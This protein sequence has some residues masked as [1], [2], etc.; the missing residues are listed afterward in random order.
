MD[1]VDSLIDIITTSPFSYLLSGVVALFVVIISTFFLLMQHTKR[2]IAS[3]GTETAVSKK[4]E[5]L[6]QSTEEKE[7]VDEKGEETMKTGKGDNDD[8]I[9]DSSD[10]HPLIQA[11]HPAISDPVGYT[12]HI[13]G[14]VKQAR[15]KY[16]TKQI[17]KKMTPNQIEE[18][19]ETQRRQLAAIYS[20]MK[21]SEDKFGVDSV[22]EVNEQFKLYA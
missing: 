21:E 8:G 18:E 22:T 17:E 16:I 14:K 19:R 2:Q 1:F 13:Q 15:A 11:E 6:K 5:K 9:V 12:E 10:I 7:V 20:L 3:M 4:S